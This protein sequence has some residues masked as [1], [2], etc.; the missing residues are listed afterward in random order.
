[1]SKMF[2]WYISHTLVTFFKKPNMDRQFTITSHI[3]TFIN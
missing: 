3:H 1:M 2:E